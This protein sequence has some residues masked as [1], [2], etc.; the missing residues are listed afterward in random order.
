[1]HNLNKM[2]PGKVQQSPK[3]PEKEKLELPAIP[4]KGGKTPAKNASGGKASQMTKQS[5]KGAGSKKS[6]APTQGTQAK[7][8][9]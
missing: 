6:Q 1:M 7:G 2:S 3:A 4:E 8:V 9:A 5:Q